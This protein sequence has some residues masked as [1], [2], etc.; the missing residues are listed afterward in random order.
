LEATSQKFNSERVTVK[1][2]FEFIWGEENYNKVRSLSSKKKK[3]RTINAPQIEEIEEEIEVHAE[4]RGH[5][6]TKYVMGKLISAGINSINFEEKA[7][8]MSERY[9]NFQY[10]CMNASDDEIAS[11]LMLEQ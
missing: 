5:Q 8:I 1:Q 2:F 6:D 10:F 7:I 11:V 3:A 9:G 4:N